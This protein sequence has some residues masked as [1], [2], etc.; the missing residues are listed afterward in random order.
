VSET[1]KPQIGFTG[2]RHGMTAAQ[3]EAVARLL[4]ELA[5]AAFVGHHGDCVGADAEFHAL[6]RTRPGSV[7][8]I[9][10]GP[11]S[12]RE[13][14]AGC[15]GDDLREAL[16]HMRRNKNIVLASTVMIAAPFEDAEQDYGGTWKTIGMARKARR[17]LAI[18]QRSGRVIRER[19][20]ALVGPVTSG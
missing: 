5:P 2:T 18:L 15:L 4:D 17:P 9:H 7:L 6:C 8:V 19:W 20:E 3:R 12:D 16:P 10:P 11:V 14:Q 13:H 1:D